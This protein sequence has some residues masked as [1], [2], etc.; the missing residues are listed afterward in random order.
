M[1]RVLTT[2]AARYFMLYL[3][4]RIARTGNMH[5]ETDLARLTDAA[6]GG[7]G[8]VGSR[9]QVSR[10]GARPLDALGIVLLA[11]LLAQD[12]AF[13]SKMWSGTGCT[14][15]SWSLPYNETIT[16][17][18]ANPRLPEGTTKRESIG[19]TH[20]AGRAAGAEAGEDLHLGVRAEELGTSALHARG[21]VDHLDRVTESRDGRNGVVGHGDGGEGHGE[22][23]E[24]REGCDE[25]R[26]HLQ[27]A[28]RFVDES[29][30]RESS[31]S[32]F[33]FQRNTRDNDN[34]FFRPSEQDPGVP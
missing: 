7:V 1:L 5:E 28:C 13:T 33:F 4:T 12:R 26:L 31:V 24:A 2:C 17:T 9:L 16:A 10:G 18:I 3:T 15:I 29:R 19:A 23:G 8:V 21:D 32:L 30:G 11:V 14:L 25:A 27:E 6:A 22:G 34:T 20:H